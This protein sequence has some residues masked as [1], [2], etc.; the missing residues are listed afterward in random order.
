MDKMIKKLLQFRLKK[1]LDYSKTINVYLDIAWH[2]KKVKKYF[3]CQ[4]AKR[5][6]NV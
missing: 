5:K 2:K 6:D 1:K 4:K 3:L